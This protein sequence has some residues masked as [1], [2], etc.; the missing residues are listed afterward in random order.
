MPAKRDVTMRVAVLLIACLVFATLL[1]LDTGGLLSW[2]LSWMV[3][4]VAHW[5]TLLLVPFA[6]LVV[7]AWHQKRRSTPAQPRAN[8]ARSSGR[9]TPRRPQKSTSPRRRRQ[10]IATKGQR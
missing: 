5:R 10:S 7:R 8:R 2:A 1:T 3:R 9:T 4:G 6:A